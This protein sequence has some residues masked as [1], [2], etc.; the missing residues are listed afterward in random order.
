MS[1]LKLKEELQ[2]DIEQNRGTRYANRLQSILDSDS[3]AETLKRAAESDHRPGELRP[4]LDY[5]GSED[6]GDAGGP[7]APNQPRTYTRE[8]Y[9][10]AAK[11]PERMTREEFKDWETAAEEGRVKD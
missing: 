6:G 1:D 8:E 9:E 10:A 5:V 7:A 3:P 2:F 4:F 11:H